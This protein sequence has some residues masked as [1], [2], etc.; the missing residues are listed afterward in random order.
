MAKWAK[1]RKHDGVKEDL[2][3]TACEKS[4]TEESLALRPISIREA[5]SRTLHP[6][7]ALN[8]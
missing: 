6:E 3:R 8:H 5:L 2:S 1:C 4:A 7:S